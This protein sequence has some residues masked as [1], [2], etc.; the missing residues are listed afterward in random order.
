MYIY[1]Y[2]YIYIHTNTHYATVPAG[3]GG[4][5]G[6]TAQ[7]RASAGVGQAPA[8]RLSSSGGV[9]EALYS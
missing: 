6:L 3:L 7:G 2:I 8:R 4:L 1:I 9:A 5:R